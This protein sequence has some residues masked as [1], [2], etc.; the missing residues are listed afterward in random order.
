MLKIKK[1]VTNPFKTV[2]VL[3][4]TSEI[5]NEICQKLVQNGT[6]KFHFISRSKARNEPFIEKLIQKFNVQVT[7]EELDL[8][9]FDIM[10][11]PYIGFYDLYLIAAGYLGDSD[12]ASKDEYEAFKISKINYYS[13]IP[14]LNAITSKDRILKSGSLWILTSVAGDVGRPS[15]Y[16]YGASKAALTIF[17][18]GLFNKCCGKPFRIRIIKAGLIATSMTINKAPRFLCISPNKFANNLLK[19]P[20]KEGIEY[21]PYWW[22]FVMRLI[23]IMPRFIITKL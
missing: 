15:N 18:Q 8:L 10:T 7:I 12:L 3:G 22:L 17:C 14:W 11:K 21:S 13:L 6:K 19:K 23:S 2:L 20:Y 5:A 1:K 4:G 9:E 16:Q